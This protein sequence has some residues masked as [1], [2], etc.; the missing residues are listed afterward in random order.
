MILYANVWCRFRNG[1]DYD[2]LK[3]LNG[4]NDYVLLF[5]IIFALQVFLFLYEE[6][7]FSIQNVIYYVGS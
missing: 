7:K 2:G 6:R 5:V 3:V 4:V 1:A